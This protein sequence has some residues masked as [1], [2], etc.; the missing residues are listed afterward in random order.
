MP[1]RLLWY[2]QRSAIVANNRAVAGYTGEPKLIPESQLP[3]FDK[4]L[5]HI[6]AFELHVKDPRID[7]RE[8]QFPR[9]I[10]DI[11]QRAAR[12]VQR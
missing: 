7:Y 3:L 11:V 9:E 4:L 6:E 10:Y 2:S 5:S 8:H 1:N 12:N